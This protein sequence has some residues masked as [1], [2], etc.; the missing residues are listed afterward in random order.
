M[1]FLIFYKFAAIS[2]ILTEKSAEM[3][4]VFYRSTATAA[5]ATPPNQKQ[6]KIGV[7]NI[8]RNQSTNFQ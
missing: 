5:G 2:T 4:L 7:A 8:V 3:A 1:P 6:Y